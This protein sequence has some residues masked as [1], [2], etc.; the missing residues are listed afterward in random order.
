MEYINID[1]NTV[2]KDIIIKHIKIKF[3]FAMLRDSLSFSLPIIPTL[4]A[5]W[6]IQQSDKIFIADYLSMEDV[7]I[8]SLSKRIAGLLTLVSGAFMLAY[9]PLYFEIANQDDKIDAKS[10]LYKYNNVFILSI[11][12]TIGSKD[13][14]V[15][16]EL[17]SK[18]RLNVEKKHGFGL[19]EVNKIVKK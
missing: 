8:F 16:D 3:K 18:K 17:F 9:H 10:K 13:E 2:I 5:A 11:A 15:I 4:I 6:I 12:N 19:F 7:G 14:I 1:A